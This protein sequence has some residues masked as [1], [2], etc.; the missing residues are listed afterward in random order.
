MK[1]KM[2]VFIL[3][4]IGIFSGCQKTPTTTVTDNNENITGEYTD[5][6]IIK[7]EVTES[8]E[9][10]TVVTITTEEINES[11]QV[12]NKTITFKGTISIPDRTDGL[13]TY[14]AVK[15]SYDE[16]F[17]NMRFLF[18]KYEDEAYVPKNSFTGKPKIGQLEVRSEDGYCASIHNSRAE[19]IEVMFPPSNIHFRV[20]WDPIVEE[21]EVPIY[22]TNEEARG[23]ADEVINKIG[24]DGFEFHE[25]TYG[26]NPVSEGYEPLMDI[27]SVIY[28]QYLQGIPVISYYGQHDECGIM[29]R[30]VSRG[31]DSVYISE[32]SFERIARNSKCLSYEEALE[33]FKEYVDSCNYYDGAIFEDISFQY[34]IMEEYIDGEKIRLV[35][36][37]YKFDAILE[38]ALN[39]QFPDIFVDARNGRVYSRTYIE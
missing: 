12:G 1:K 17:E 16:Y 10:M 22:M 37:C 23:K 26:H 36:P 24:V 5:D 4:T 30:F 33:C 32:Y 18:G 38:P 21:S 9:D 6:V 34:I 27:L 2:M 13:Y 7:D 20:N 35:V 28:R 39:N 14:K 3:V 25:S 19:D 11:F 31:L 8:W 15:T 29:V